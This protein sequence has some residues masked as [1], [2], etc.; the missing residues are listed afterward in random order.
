[1][2]K[3]RVETLVKSFTDE[4][5]EVRH[6]VI[7]AVSEVLPRNIGESYM[8][9]GDEDEDE[10]ELSHEV[11]CYDEWDSETIDYVVKSLRLGWAICNPVDTFNEEIGKQI[12]IGRA[13]KNGT[14]A[15]YATKLGYINTKVVRA[16]LEQ[17]AEFFMENPAT[18]IAG[19]KR[20][21]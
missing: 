4:N 6:F 13:R 19:Y 14:A 8:A 7:A 21:K 16:F 11:V 9:S 3:E 2:K 12:A 15:L 10:C 18:M 17:E 1:M 20:K 5:G